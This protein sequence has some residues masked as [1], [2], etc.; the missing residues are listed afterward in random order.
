[1]WLFLFIFS[2]VNLTIVLI[3]AQGIAFVFAVSV[4]MQYND[5]Q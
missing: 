3:A 4:W 5:K 2:I 1:M